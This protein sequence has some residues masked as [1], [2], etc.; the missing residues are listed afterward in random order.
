MR[1]T[2]TNYQHLQAKTPFSTAVFD[3]IQAMKNPVSLRAKAALA[4]NAD[5]RVGLTGTPIENSTVDLW[6]IMEQLTLGRLGSLK[7]F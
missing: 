1:T 7:A 2:L 6:V 5:F 4:V 3:E